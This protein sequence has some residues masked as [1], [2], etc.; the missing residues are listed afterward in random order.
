M[1]ISEN[2]AKM[3]ATYEEAQS[4]V[5]REVLEDAVTLHLASLTAIE[6]AQLYVLLHDDR[7]WDITKSRKVLEHRTKVGT[8]IWDALLYWC[9]YS[10]G[11]RIEYAR[12]KAR[13]DESA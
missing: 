4:T 12:I 8:Q 2:D 1:S 11:E 10:Q 9:L 7:G 6:R 3:I 5:S 13:E